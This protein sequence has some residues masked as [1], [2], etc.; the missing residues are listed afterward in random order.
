[1]KRELKPVEKI[2]YHEIERSLE[3]ADPALKNERKKTMA[4]MGRKPFPEHKR[5]KHQVTV[6][7]NDAEI[8]VLENMLGDREL[9]E[10]VRLLAM[11]AATSHTEPIT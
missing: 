4:K 1:M 7:F 6:R 5:R 10:L 3:V 9:A 11:E 2:I 8:E